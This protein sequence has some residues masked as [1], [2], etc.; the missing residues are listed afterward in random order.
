VDIKRANELIVLV[1]QRNREG[2]RNDEERA[3]YDRMRREA[4]LNAEYGLTGIDLIH[5]HD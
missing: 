2:C 3:D 1:A 4:D 5:D